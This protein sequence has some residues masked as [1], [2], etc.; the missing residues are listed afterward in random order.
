MGVKTILSLEDLKKIFPSYGFIKILP[1]SSGIID[2]TYIVY[3]KTA[4]YILKKYERNIP[5][6]IVLDAQLLKQL[7]SAGLNVPLCLGKNDGWHLYTRLTGEQPRTIKSYHIQAVARFLAKLHCATSK[8]I[9]DSNV[10]IEDEVTDALKYTKL[11]HFS[12][13][14]KF[15]FLKHFSHEDAVLIH[16]DIFKDNTIFNHKKV[17]VIDFIDSS[18]GT[19]SFDAAVTLVG[20][21]ARTHHDYFI[22]IF[23][24][25]YNQHAPKKL[26][27]KVVKEKMKIAAHFYALKRVY[28]YK[29]TLRA[30]ELLR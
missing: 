4:S 9:C 3:T 2:T 14:K 25:A 19:L 12:Y 22:N 30:K 23:L 11:H 17:G 13:Y 29:N 27:K 24:N 15:E 1:T 7:N 20:F 5:R 21:D 6:K 26:T 16:G 10:M 18:C 28:T 8:N